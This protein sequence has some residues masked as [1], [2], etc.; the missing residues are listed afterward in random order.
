M[1][2]EATQVEGCQGRSYKELG[3]GGRSWREKTSYEKED[4]SSS[5]ID[6]DP[7]FQEKKTGREIWNLRFRGRSLQLYSWMIIYFYTV[8]E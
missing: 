3:Q 8:L 2:E 5:Q 6:E 4:P 7:S 1:A